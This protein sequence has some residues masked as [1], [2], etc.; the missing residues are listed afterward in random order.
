MNGRHRDDQGLCED[1]QQCYDNAAEK[2]ETDSNNDKVQ[3]KNAKKKVW[4]T[5]GLP[6]VFV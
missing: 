4:E 5:L 2:F 1:G 6:N 3:K